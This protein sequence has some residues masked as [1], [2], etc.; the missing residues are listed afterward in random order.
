[1]VQLKLEIKYE[2][3]LALVTKEYSSFDEVDRKEYFVIEKSGQ[4]LFARENYKKVTIR[5]L[6]DG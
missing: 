4:G 5:K 6:S 3:L 1:V 2:R